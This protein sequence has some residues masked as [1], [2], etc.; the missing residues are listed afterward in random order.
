MFCALTPA[1]RGSNSEHQTY[2]QVSLISAY[3]DLCFRKIT[4]MLALRG[5][6][7]VKKDLSGGHC[8]ALGKSLKNLNCSHK[9]SAK[10]SHS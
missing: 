3:T 5:K 6:A 2:N 9:N 4:L 10:C 7:N 8:S 1:S